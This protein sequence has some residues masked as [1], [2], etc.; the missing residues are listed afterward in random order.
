MHWGEAG[1][2]DPS[3]AQSGIIII[4]LAQMDSSA[5]AL[6]FLQQQKSLGYSIKESNDPKE[7]I[8]MGKDYHNEINDNPDPTDTSM[9]SN[10]SKVKLAFK[11]KPISFI[12]PVGF[13]VGGMYIQDSGWTAITTFFNDK[14]LGACK[15][16][17]NNMKLSQ[18][19]VRIAKETVRYDINKKVTN[20]FVEGS[21]H[22]GFIYNVDWNDPTFNY[23]LECANMNFDKDITNRMIELAKKIDKNS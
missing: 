23:F 16:K 10:L 9:K 20:V 2:A 15:F 11:F 18:G 8:K 21:T 1:P 4:P 14:D 5:E 3:K 13:A 17:L 12:N 6:S 7:M 19:A 22:S